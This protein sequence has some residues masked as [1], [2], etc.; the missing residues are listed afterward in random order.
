MAIKPVSKN[1]YPDQ[2]YFGS[3]KAWDAHRKALDQIYDLKSQVAG[4]RAEMAKSR[5]PAAAKPTGP[6][7]EG[8]G[9]AKET[10]IAGY[11]VRPSVLQGT[12]TLKYNSKTEQLEFS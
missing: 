10:Y 8:P 9:S 11:L 2:S 7:H 3:Y 12:E 1:W 5:P 6:P 4:L